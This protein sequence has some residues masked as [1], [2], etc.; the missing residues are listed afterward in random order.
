M[1]KAMGPHA[2]SPCKGDLVAFESRQ[3]FSALESQLE[4]HPVESD[5]DLPGGLSLRARIQEAWGPGVRPPTWLSEL[6]VC[7]VCNSTAPVC[8]C[9]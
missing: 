8:V 4:A 1:K 5:D 7:A 3:L 6:F 9:C 2:R